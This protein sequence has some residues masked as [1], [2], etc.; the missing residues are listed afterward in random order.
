MVNKCKIKDMNYSCFKLNPLISFGKFV[1]EML[2]L[3][4]VAFGKVFELDFSGHL[5][6]PSK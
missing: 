4:N 3:G 5:K 1:W 2:R 6:P